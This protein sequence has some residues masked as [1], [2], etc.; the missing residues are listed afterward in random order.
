VRENLAALRLSPSQTQALNTV[1]TYFISQGDT[2]KAQ[3]I[4]NRLLQIDP[5]SNEAKTRGYLFVNA[6]D[7]EDALK[8][9][10]DAVASHDTALAGHDI[11]AYA[12]LLLGNI[13]AAQQEAEQ[14]SALAPNNYLG[15]SLKAMIAAANNDRPGCEAALKTFE[16]DAE[17]VHWAAMRQALCYA[18]LG[19]RDTAMRWV[20]RAAEGGNHSWFAWVKHPWLEPLQSDPEF[21]Q[22][23]SKMKADLDDVRDDVIGVYQLICR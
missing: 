5:S 12:Y 22:I 11:R 23:L 2:Q 19:D 17:R 1:G 15:K 13:P 9:S 8:A 20:R 7:P 10:A 16:A 6:V 21:Q 18:K 3:C 4:T 14:A